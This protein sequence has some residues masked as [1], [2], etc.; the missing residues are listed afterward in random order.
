MA[1]KKAQASQLYNE[2]AEQS[3]L[4][5]L[6]TGSISVEDCQGKLNRDAFASKK[7]Q[8]IF[9]ACLKV[10]ERGSPPDLPLV[11][12]YMDDASYLASLANDTA[13]LDVESHIKAVRDLYVRRQVQEESKKLFQKAGQIDDDIKTVLDQAQT[14]L[15]GLTA[16]G[17]GQALR[18]SQ[19]L[20]PVFQSIEEG[21]INI[22]AGI[23]TGFGSIDGIISGLHPTDL[24]IIAARPRMGKSTLAGQIQTQLAITSIPTAFF[25]LEMDR[26][27]IVYRLL[28]SMAHVDY[29]NIRRST[30]T[31]NELR[32]LYNAASTLH[33]LPIYIDDTPGLPIYEVKSRARELVQKQGV[34]A[35][36]VDYLTKIRPSKRS[37]TRDQE[38]THI[39]E[40]FKNLAKELHIP[41]VCLAQ[42]NRKCDD[43]KNPRPVLSDLRESGGIEQ[44]ADN[45]WFLYRDAVYKKTEDRTAEVKIAKQRNGPEG[46]AKLVWLGEYQSF[47]ELEYEVV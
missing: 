22:G 8:Q 26:Q 2:Y 14:T 6:L 4:G 18:L 9:D 46:T 44:E 28:S 36:F 19:I 34:Q 39:T 33:N 21:G 43:R 10:H 41:V 38:V 5:A 40:E 25:S 31:D 17:D 20:E 13:R 42:L 30:L 7:H 23:P 27:Q 3:V 12:Q 47:E 24:T 45:I 11:S 32:A 16:N 1:Q 37:D 15:M 29:Q 35:I